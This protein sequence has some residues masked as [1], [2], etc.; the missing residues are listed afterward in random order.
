MIA[1]LDEVRHAFDALLDGSRTR[2]D[3]SAWA[4]AHDSADDAGNLTFD[5]P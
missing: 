3:V 2:Q 1:R 4:F 5:P